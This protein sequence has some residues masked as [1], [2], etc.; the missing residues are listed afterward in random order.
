[1][2]EMKEQGKIYSYHNFIYPF[3]WEDSARKVNKKEIIESY[4]ENNEYWENINRDNE[5]FSKSDW[6]KLYSKNEYFHAAFKEAILGYNDKY[7]CDKSIV[8]QYE[9]NKKYI[10][11]GAE[12]T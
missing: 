3:I 2:S 5:V 7:K 4:F 11:K 12:Y 8:A 9:F 1:M 10:S 6:I